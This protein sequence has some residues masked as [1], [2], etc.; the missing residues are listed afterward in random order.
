MEKNQPT[1][2]R[3]E[4]DD[5]LIAQAVSGNT[6]T[7]AQIYDNY[8]RDIYRYSYS[9]VGNADDAEDLTAQ[10]FMAVI[11]ALPRYRHRGHFSAWIFRIAY[12]K[13]ID[14]FRKQRRDPIDIPLDTAHTDGVL[15]QIIQDQTYAKLSALLKTL[16][17]DERELIRLR[18]V[19]EM[20][21]VEIAV[22]LARREDAVRKSLS[23]ILE[24][25]YSQIEVPH[26]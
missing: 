17:E 6:A 8:A 11:E 18:Y 4:I 22:M 24:R 3:I 21:F 9:R 23:R 15:D 10:T 14:F 2:K 5:A 13:I 20:S 16:E 25:L 19:A 1:P 7:L 12:S 26:V